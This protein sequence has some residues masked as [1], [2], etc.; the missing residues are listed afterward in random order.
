MNSNNFAVIM[1]G[2]VGSRFWPFS[3]TDFPKQFHDVLGSGKSLLQETV[4]RFANICPQENIFIVTNSS[5]KELVLEQLPFLKEEQVLLEVVGKNTAPCIAYASYKIRTKNADANI[6]I[7]PSDHIILKDAEYEDRLKIALR[8]SADKNVLVTLGI[9]PSRPDTGYG[10]IRFEKGVNE[11]HHVLNF[12]EKPQL[13]IAKAF[14]SSGEYVWNAGI[15]IFRASTVI[16]AFE[17][18]EPTLAQEFADGIDKYYTSE[19]QEFVDG[20]YHKT[21][22]ISIDYAVMERAENVFVVLSDIGWSDLGTWKSLYEMKDKDKDNNVLDGNIVTYD[23]KD[24]IIKT[25]KERLVVTQGLEGYIVAE[26]DNVL[27]ICKKDEEQKVKEFV[28]DLKEKEANEF[29]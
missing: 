20:V 29:V 24:C 26:Y 4:N 7:A 25:P 19:E 1:A 16:N 5:Y 13:E 9:K 18:F 10:Y 3:R 8:E 2:G 28:N 15:F 6:I 27:M 23:T 14:V 22:N 12:T 17:K 21:K 11:V